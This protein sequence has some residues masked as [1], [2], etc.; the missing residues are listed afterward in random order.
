M[1]FVHQDKVVAF[2]GIDGHG[3][4]TGGFAEFVDVDDLNSKLHGSVFI[5]QFR[6]HVGK[7]KFI[8]ML[9]A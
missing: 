8:N 9:E 7:V 5:E 3:F 2:E 6:I 1:A 4:L